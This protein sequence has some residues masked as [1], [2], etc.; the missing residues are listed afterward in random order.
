MTNW[1][2]VAGDFGGSYKAVKEKLDLSACTAKIKVWRE[3]EA[4]SA[5]ASD[6]AIGQAD[7]IVTNVS[8]FEVGE[9]VRIEDDTPQYEH[10]QIASIDTPTKTLTMV[11]TL[12]K[13]YTVVKAAKVLMRLLIYAKACGTITYDAAEEESYC[14]YDVAVG[15]FPLTA[16]VGNRMTIYEVMVEFTKPGYKEHDLGFEWHVFPAPPEGE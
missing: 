11:T 13:T 4:L 9:Y 5:L 1:E 14:Y 12:A 7:V 6:A 3:P 16:A 15:D 8:G 10:N 2:I